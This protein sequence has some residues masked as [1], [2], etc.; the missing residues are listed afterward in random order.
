MAEFRHGRRRCSPSIMDVLTL[1]GK[2][3]DSHL[4]E[5]RTRS[6][7]GLKTLLAAGGDIQFG[8]RVVSA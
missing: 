4:C 8:A 2:V 1:D 6:L 5:E 3:I 7:I